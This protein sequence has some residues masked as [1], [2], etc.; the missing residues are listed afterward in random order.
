MQTVKI[1]WA[2]LTSLFT[3]MVEAKAFVPFSNECKP[4]V[5]ALWSACPGK[6]PM[7]IEWVALSALAAWMVDAIEIVPFSNECNPAVDALLSMKPDQP[8]QIEAVG[9]HPIGALLPPLNLT[10]KCEACGKEYSLLKGY[11]EEGEYSYCPGCCH[12]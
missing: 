3:W 1:E 6:R 10:A 5:D 2:A 4:A 12:W 9:E 11:Y 7:G 8:G